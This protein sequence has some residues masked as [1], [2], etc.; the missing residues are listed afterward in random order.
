MKPATVKRLRLL[1]S[2]LGVLL[3]IVL[4]LGAWFYIRMRASLPQL[5]GS[6]A[7]TG[8]GARVTV[9]RDA[10]GVP[11][12]RG[13]NRN[14]VARALGFI[15]AQDRFFQMDCTRRHA[16]GELAELCGK[17]ALAHDRRVRIHNFRTLAQTVLAKLPAEQ[18]ALVEAYTA[19]ANAGLAALKTEP[20]EYLLLREN[21]QPWKAE[22]CVLMIYAMAL[23]LQDEDA[24]YER[25]LATL[26]DTLGRSSVAYFAPLLGPDDA[27]LDG[28]TGSLAPMPTDHMIDIRKRV[29]EYEDNKKHAYRTNTESPE[30]LPG[31]NA[32]ALSGEHT[33]TGAGLVANDMHLTLRVPNTWYRASL[34]FPSAKGDGETRITGVTIP[35]APLVVAGSNGHIAWGFT[36]A[37]VDTTD[38]IIVNV[39]A[40]AGTYMNR[41]EVMMYEKRSDTI[42][43]HGQ[44]P[45]SIDYMST[46]WGPIIGANADK[47]DLALKW[48]EHDPAATNF[49]LFNL[50]SARTVQ[51]AVEIAHRTGIP[52][53]NFIVADADGAIAWTICGQVPKRVGYDG[54][55]SATW[56]FGDRRWDGFLKTDEVPTL[57]APKG[58]RLWSANQRMAGDDFLRVLG[59]GG[60]E[61]PLRAGR[62]RDLLAPLEKAS[63]LDLLAVQLDVRA[64]YLDRWQQL[65][66]KVLSPEAIA[67]KKGRPEMRSAA[68]KWEGQASVDSVSYRLVA[69]F[70]QHVVDRVLPVVF[71]PCYDAFITKMHSGTWW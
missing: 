42:R 55:L 36:N 66:L 59:D 71:E 62:I 58:G 38:L 67:Q 51:E 33:T 53:Q 50:E 65:F 47:R 26:N 22:D 1:A 68:E 11:T 18:R 6:A 34:I 37:Y 39:A 3:L 17:V 49:D 25:S 19:G 32:F 20:F 52:P 2:A 54:R 23:D 46:I 14:D 31:S 57:I 28:T 5:D 29:Y 41:D 10:Q 9:E 16:A 40:G 13:A 48:T 27:A 43:V 70:R 21:P 63:A 24:V 44:K 45:E 35:G 4:V 64:S 60:Y 7:M 8:L 12:L 15:H 30:V 61:R 56:S 69:A